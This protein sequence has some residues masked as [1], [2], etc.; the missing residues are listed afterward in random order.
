MLLILTSPTIHCHNLPFCCLFCFWFPSSNSYM[1][2]QALAF[3]RGSLWGGIPISGCHHSRRMAKE[4]LPS[5]ITTSFSNWHQ[6][7]LDGCNHSLQSY[8]LL[9][10]TALIYIQNVIKCIPIWHRANCQHEVEKYANSHLC[11]FLWY[12]HETLHT[13]CCKY[14][15]NVKFFICH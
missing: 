14:M 5:S 11:I 10:F 8:L 12:F 2:P 15:N 4:F 6:I 3:W 13:S 1:R 7:I 9:V